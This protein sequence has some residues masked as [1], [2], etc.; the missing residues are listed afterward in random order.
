MT[1]ASHEREPD[2][3]RSFG[4]CVPKREFGNEMSYVNGVDVRSV[5][6][7]IWR[8]PHSSPYF[9]AVLVGA[10]SVAFRLSSRAC[11]DLMSAAF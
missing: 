7:R 2:S 11:I 9:E 4:K 6:R 8:A 3:K 10:I 5:T 1:R